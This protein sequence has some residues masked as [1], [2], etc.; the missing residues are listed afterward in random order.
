MEETSRLSR[1]IND[2]LD[3]SK[4]EA[5]GVDWNLIPIDNP[6][7]LIY[8]VIKTFTALAEEHELELTTD[9]APS[10][11]TIRGDRDR[12]I[13]VVTNLCSNAVKFTPPGGRILVSAKAG[14]Y[15]GRPV[16]EVSVTDTGRGIPEGDLETI[17]DRFRQAGTGQAAGKTAGTGLGLAICREVVTYHDGTIWA[18][19]PPRGGA[20]V[21]FVIPTSQPEVLDS[22]THG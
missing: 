4:I 14:D 2:L 18:E 3:L 6:A 7:D 9:V 12:L 5:G 10:L 16:V 21:V 22:V 1:L 17:F 20:R 19:I 15:H 11:P 13:Q 8:H